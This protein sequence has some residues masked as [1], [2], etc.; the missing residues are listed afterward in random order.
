MVLACRSV[1]AV[2]SL[3]VYDMLLCKHCGSWQFLS[4]FESVVVARVDKEGLC[5][6]YNARYSYFG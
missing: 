3:V 4:V 5:L 2:F 1:V 6:D